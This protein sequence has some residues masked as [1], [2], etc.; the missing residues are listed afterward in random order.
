MASIAGRKARQ[1]DKVCRTDCN[2]EEANRDERHQRTPTARRR[3]WYFILSLGGWKGRTFFAT[4]YC[5]YPTSLQVAGIVML[6]SI[7]SA[8]S[9]RWNSTL[10]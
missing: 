8:R 5:V 9:G 3:E 6:I 2:G 7:M 10:V 1:D 4:H